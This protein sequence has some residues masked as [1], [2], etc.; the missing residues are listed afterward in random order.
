MLNR[1]AT[2]LLGVSILVLAGSNTE[3]QQSARSNARAAQVKLSEALLKR[4]PT[5]LSEKAGSLLTMTE[6]EQQ[7]LL[8]LSDE[9]LRASISG[10]L[11]NTKPEAADFLIT[12]LE[13]EPSAK[14]RSAIIR[15]WKNRP[16][17]HANPRLLL[18]L[19]K[20]ITSDP[21]TGVSLQ[22]VE[23]LRG[24]RTNEISKLLTTRL[25]TARRAGDQKAA[26]QLAAEQE[27][28]I[29]IE[30]GTMLPSFMRASPPVFSLKAAGQPVRVVA[31]GDFGTGSEAQQQVASALLKYHRQTSFDFGITLGDNFYP[32][33]MESPRDPRWTTQWEQLYQALGIKFYATL[34]NH[35]WG[36]PDSPAA[37]II[38]SDRSQTWRMPS[39][40]YTFTAG[41]VQFFALDTNRISEAQLI[42]LKEELSRSQAKWKVTYGHHHIYSATRGDNRELIG[43][44]LPVLQGGGVDIYICGHDHNLQHVRPEG[45]VHFFVA[46]GG[47]AGTYELN[48]YERT[49]FKAQ[50]HGFAVLEADEKRLK[51]KLVGADGAQAYEYALEKQGRIAN[52]R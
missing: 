38:Y 50:K 19:E 6:A 24:I 5:E 26:K 13:K 51:V 46:G 4:L 27:R 43:R 8:R 7:R 28:W 44:L 14:V 17:W 16:H 23:V 36:H 41:Q 15:Y 12:F 39:P 40:Y 30:N 52:G 1:I 11:S 2:L 31:F 25:E 3:A 37:E 48:E 21:D 33:G 42:W 49:I 32:V 10:Q 47:G 22:A 34:G 45:G 29:S 9:D 18:T 35:D 20:L